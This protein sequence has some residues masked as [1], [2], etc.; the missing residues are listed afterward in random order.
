ML[1]P[2]IGS[3]V[4]TLLQ[5][6]LLV[7]QTLYIALPFGTLFAKDQVKVVLLAGAIDQTSEVIFGKGHSGFEGVGRR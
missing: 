3:A 7:E 5:V 4:N 6:L 1:S 2:R